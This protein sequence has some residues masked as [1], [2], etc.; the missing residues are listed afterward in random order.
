MGNHTTLIVPQPL[1]RVSNWITVFIILFALY[2]QQPLLIVIPLLYFG[3][4]AFFGKNPIIFIGKHFLR[5]NRTYIMED[6]DQLA[7]NSLLAFIMLFLALVFFY[8]GLP[9]VYYIFIIMCALANIGAILGFCVGC[10]IRF[11]WKQ[12]RYRRSI[13]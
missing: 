7:F 8:L 1:V 13:R 5:K 4:G 10:F 9:I 12:Y 2:T 6:R 3:L 11:Q